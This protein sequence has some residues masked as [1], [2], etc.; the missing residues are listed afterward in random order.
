MKQNYHFIPG[1]TATVALLEWADQY[2]AHC[3]A[4][5]PRCSDK[6]HCEEKQDGWHAHACLFCAA[7]L[8]VDTGRQFLQL[9]EGREGREQG[10]NEPDEAKLLFQVTPLV[11]DNFECYL[12]GGMNEARN[13]FCQGFNCFCGRLWLMYVLGQ[14]FGFLQ[15]VGGLRVQGLVGIVQKLYG[16]NH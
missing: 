8:E 4:A 9:M 2:T 10:L 3:S 15:V 5:H 16:H 14:G 7:P 1:V 12:V 13:A 6:F 11:D